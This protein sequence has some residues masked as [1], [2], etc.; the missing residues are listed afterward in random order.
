[1]NQIKIER[2]KQSMSQKRLAMLAGIDARTLRK[3]EKDEP[4]SL[5]SYRSA[6]L[7]LR[8]EPSAV[9]GAPSAPT[10]ELETQAGHDDWIYKTIGLIGVALL[11]AMP[12][13]ADP[14]FGKYYF[15]KY[16]NLRISASL[17]GPCEDA[18]AASTTERVER[19]LGK[20]KL[21][22]SSMRSGTDNCTVVI[23]TFV[24]GSTERDIIRSLI[25]LGIDAT[26]LKYR[27]SA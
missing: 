12:F 19:A 4:V 26:I 22:S 6:C 7:A 9:M 11:T 24:P 2:L 14:L 17:P 21:T 13:A 8:I 27:P 5:E 3:I 16:P 10:S 23:D 15:D 25:P 1:M 20:T 18:T